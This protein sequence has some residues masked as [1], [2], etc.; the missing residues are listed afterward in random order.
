MR[1]LLLVLLFF[2]FLTISSA[3][4]TKDNRSISLR[5]KTFTWDTNWNKRIIDYDE[6]LSGGP[7]RDGIPP[8]DNPKFI[9]IKKAKNWLSDNEPVIFLDID[10]K[11][12]IYPLSILM[13]HEIVNDE[14]SNKKIS[15]TFCPLCNSAIVFNRS[16]D[17]NLYDFGTSGLLRHSDLVM[18]DRQTESL[19]QQFTGEAIV[20][21]MVNKQLEILAS[22]IVGFKH[23]YENYPKALVLSKETGYIRDYGR[24][25]YSG[26]DDINENPFLFNKKSDSRFRPMQKVV[27]VSLNG[28]DKAYSYDS[29]KNKSVYN[30][31]ELNLVIFHKKGAVSA[32]DRSVIK[33]SRD[34]GAFT[35]Y[36]SFLANEKLEF[37][38]NNEEI[39]D[40]NTNSTWNIFGKAINGKLKGKKLKPIVHADHFWFSW[41]VF[42]PNTL[43]YR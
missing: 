10:E 16:L 33:N 32:L 26:Y 29:L 5:M 22:S 14:L 9:S 35:V 15:V 39:K 40:I 27:T 37:I 21:D 38:Y 8:I 41:A 20:G 34:D 28:I 11:V 24:N 19:W 7:P 1:L 18:Y 43:I 36:S 31:K 3:Y 6:L 23:A 17:G 2:S 30:D 42:K 12:K 13:W 25:P 4:E